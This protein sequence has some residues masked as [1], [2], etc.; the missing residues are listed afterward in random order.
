VTTYDSIRHLLKQARDE[1]SD[2]L[3]AGSVPE[4]DRET[5]QGFHDDVNR[6]VERMD[7]AHRATSGTGTLGRDLFALM[8]RCRGPLERYRRFLEDAISV[9]KT[10]TG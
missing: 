5:V 6:L 4:G 9:T 3:E 8:Q 2:Q 10:E 7:P 1:A